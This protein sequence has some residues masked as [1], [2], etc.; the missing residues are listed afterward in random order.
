MSKNTSTYIQA[1]R[2]GDRKVI[3]SLEDSIRFSLTTQ[4][5]DRLVGVRKMYA[6]M[7]VEKVYEILWRQRHSIRRRSDIVKLAQKITESVVKKINDKKVNDVPRIAW[8][9]IPKGTRYVRKIN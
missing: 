6:P 7:V 5:R 4:A 2:D 9:D 3:N 8:A 1:I